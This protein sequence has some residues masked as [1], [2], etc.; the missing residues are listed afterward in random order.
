MTTRNRTDVAGLDPV[1]I[2]RYLSASGWSVQQRTD[3][4]AVW[5]GGE[6]SEGFELLVPLNP[7]FGDYHA[8]LLDTVE[9]LA[10]AEDRLPTEVVADLLATTVDTQHFRLLP[11]LPSGTIL[12]VHVTDAIRGIRDLMYAA[13]HSAVVGRPMLVQPRQRPPEV[14]QFVRSVRLAAPAP[15]SFVLSAQVPLRPE[16]GSALPR[17]T[18]PSGR[19]NVED[20]APFNRRIA[21]RLHEAVRATHRAAG[22]A[23]R[24]DSLSP[25]TDQAE[26][27]VS[28]NLCAAISLVGKD[29][30]F[31]LRFSWAPSQ[32]L[33]VGGPLVTFDRPILSVIGTAASELPRMVAE[34]ED[35]ELVARV[36]ELHRVDPNPGSATIRGALRRP[37]GYVED[38]RLT[39][40]LPADLYDVAVQAHR[41][42]RQIRIAGRLRGN[43]L[44]QVRSLT[45][46]DGPG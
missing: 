2:E 46:H 13:A 36:I 6:D 45:I 21:L 4:M 17:Q 44:D 43:D 32:P 34:G 5:V 19:S 37:S 24:T 31:D 3:D 38:V 10:L 28:A 20:P 42:R 12:L 11:S 29:Q 15:G 22:E 30:P 8:R 14:H 23:I 7:A 35:V 41:T 25:F 27:G 39:A 16:P 18:S 9:T 1:D 33:T 40:T 26:A